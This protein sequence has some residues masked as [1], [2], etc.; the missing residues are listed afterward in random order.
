MQTVPCNICGE[1]RDFEEAY[2]DRPA[3]L[4]VVR[5]RGCGLVFV[6]P[7]FTSREHMEYYNTLY[8]DFPTDARGSYRDIPA[9]RI[10]RWEKRAKAQIDYLATFCQHM[11][12]PDGKPHVM[13]VG[14]GYAAHLAEV[15]RRCPDAKLTAVEPN[16]RLY[17]I[18]RKRLPDVQLLGKTLEPL[19]GVRM[20]FDCIIA[21]DV[22]QRTVDPSYTC[23]R[24]HAMLAP[25]G[26]CL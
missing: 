11:L 26:I 10:E 25:D 3:N 19:S 22:L 24:I 1:K 7:T 23:R 21:V 14:C 16:R 2:V 17:D 8:W 9:E 20:L 18:I 12:K 5:C 6:N 15:K 13:E 4:R